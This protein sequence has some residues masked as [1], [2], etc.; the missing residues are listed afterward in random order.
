VNYILSEKELP[1]LFM[2]AKAKTA[3]V[4]DYDGTLVP[5]VDNPLDTKLSAKTQKLLKQITRLYPCA[6]LSG[7]GLADVKRKV[8]GAGFHEVVGNHGMEFSHSK[9]SRIYSA[10]ASRWVQQYAKA[11]QDGRVDGRGLEFEDKIDPLS[12]RA[13]SEEI[14]A[15]TQDLF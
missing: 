9:A 2:F 10:R 4:F 6:V 15:R 3:L 5:I 12:G 7:R 1:T 8:K 14:R 13:Q 11:V